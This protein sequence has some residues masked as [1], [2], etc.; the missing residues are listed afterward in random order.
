MASTRED[1]H[2]SLIDMDT[3]SLTWTNVFRQVQL[4][5]LTSTTIPC[6]NRGSSASSVPANLGTPRCHHGA[7]SSPIESVSRFFRR[8]RLCAR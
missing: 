3:C 5:G 4:E 2:V 7:D 1:L 8:P 6:T